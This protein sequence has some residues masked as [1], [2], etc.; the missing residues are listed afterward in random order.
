M[1]GES[2]AAASFDTAIHTFSTLQSTLF[3]HCKRTLCNTA[4]HAHQAD[5]CLWVS[6]IAGTA[7]LPGAQQYA[8]AALAS[9][10][11]RLRLLGVEQLGRLLLASVG[12]A[13]QCMVLQTALVNALKVQSVLAV[14]GPWRPLS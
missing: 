2:A 7:L 14:M 13:A 10:H 8:E 9:P 3:Q 5:A 1:S 12:D 4:E 11:H 6:N